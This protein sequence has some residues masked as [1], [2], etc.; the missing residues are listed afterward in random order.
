MKEITFKQRVKSE[1]YGKGTVIKAPVDVPKE[2]FV[3]FD[4]GVRKWTM[5]YDL[6]VLEQ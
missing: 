5:N 6:E 1:K 2:S 4:N 3:T